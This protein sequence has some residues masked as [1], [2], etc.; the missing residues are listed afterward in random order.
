LAQSNGAASRWSR[1]VGR[2]RTA[3]RPGQASAQASPWRVRPSASSRR[4]LTAATRSDHHRSLRSIPPV[5]HPP[6]AG[7]AAGGVL[8][9]EVLAADAAGDRPGRV[10]PGPDPERPWRLA[11]AGGLEPLA[12]LPGRLSP[13]AVLPLALA[14][15]LSP[16]R[17]GQSATSPA[18]APRGQ[19]CRQ[20]RQV[21]GMMAGLAAR[22]APERST[23]N[24]A[25]P[26]HKARVAT[27]T[28]RYSTWKRATRSL[29]PC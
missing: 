19:P 2:V 27:I 11:A 22:G 12:G 28:R 9:L 18:I 26:Q 5:G 16:S 15:R 7:L 21:V 14:V 25:R 24:A 1:V 23:P 3:A 29:A 20:R 6:A 8:G 4:R 13:V 10:L 17:W